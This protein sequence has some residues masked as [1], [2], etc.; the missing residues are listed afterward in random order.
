MQFWVFWLSTYFF[1]ESKCCNFLIEI[2]RSSEKKMNSNRVE[3][4]SSTG[5]IKMIR[6]THVLRS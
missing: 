5:V 1:I 3:I 4:D 2:F 6:A